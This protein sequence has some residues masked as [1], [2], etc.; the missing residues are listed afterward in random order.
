M[1]HPTGNAYESTDRQSQSGSRSLLNLQGRLLRRFRH[2]Q[3]VPCRAIASGDTSLACARRAVP[4]EMA[5]IKRIPRSHRSVVVRWPVLPQPAVVV[6]FP[7]RRLDVTF[8]CRCLGQFVAK[9]LV[10]CAP[11]HPWPV[12]HRA[13][14]PV[15]KITSG[16]LVPFTGP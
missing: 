12:R 14:L 8:I 7:R 11:G 13:P 3:A 6:G 2:A 15:I 4:V 5:H 16:T 10:N 1:R 9:N